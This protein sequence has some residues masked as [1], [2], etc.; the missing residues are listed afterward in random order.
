MDNR[1]KKTQAE[2]I[3][4]RVAGKPRERGHRLMGQIVREK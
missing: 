2:T 1:R 3:H 4:E